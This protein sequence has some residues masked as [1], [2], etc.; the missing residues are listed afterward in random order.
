MLP[1]ALGIPR[2]PAPE[3]SL[4][5]PVVTSRAVLACSL[6]APQI[7]RLLRAKLLMRVAAAR[8]PRRPPIRAGRGHP[9]GRH[10]GLRAASRAESIS[11]A[12]LNAR[13]RPGE[14]LT[15]LDLPP[16]VDLALDLDVRRLGRFVDREEA[17]DEAERDQVGLARQDRS[18]EGCGRVRPGQSRRGEGEKDQCATH[19][20]A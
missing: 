8:R 7:V 13:Q 9:G 3:R 6:P 10:R 20:P 2:S 1:A 19:R 15:V 17:L 11:V 4:A 14:R 16:A 5:R 18:L 12:E